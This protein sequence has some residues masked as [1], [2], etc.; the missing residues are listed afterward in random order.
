MA[1][2]NIY[3]KEIAEQSIYYDDVSIIMKKCNIIEALS[4]IENGSTISECSYQFSNVSNE[5]K[6]LKINYIMDIIQTEYETLH[7]VINVEEFSVLYRVMML[8]LCNK[9]S[10]E[11]SSE[12]HISS[13]TCFQCKYIIFNHIAKKIEQSIK[14]A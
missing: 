3:K 8:L 6:K 7:S 12:L 13:R 11:I 14:A 10:R 9:T 5:I 4:K 2:S 1:I